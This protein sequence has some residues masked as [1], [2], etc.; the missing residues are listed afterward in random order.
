M[1]VEEGK[2]KGHILAAPALLLL[3]EAAILAD[4]ISICK[5]KPVLNIA[6]R[7]SHLISINNGEIILAVE[8]CGV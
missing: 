8:G 1:S 5:Q 7:L 2:W 6:E 4:C 3:A